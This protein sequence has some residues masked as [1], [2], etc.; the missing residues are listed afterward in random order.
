MSPR[1]PRSIRK[2][3][4]KGEALLAVKRNVLDTPVTLTELKHPNATEILSNKDHRW[5]DCPGYDK[6]L[7]IA[8]LLN[9]NCWSCRNCAVL[10]QRPK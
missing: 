9:W 3:R 5:M 1:R 7:D 4:E 10:F 8:A 2:D 6:C